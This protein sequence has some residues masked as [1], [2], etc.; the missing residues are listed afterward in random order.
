MTRIHTNAK[1]TDFT[2]GL[3]TM[4]REDADFWAWRAK[5]SKPEPAAKPGILQRIFGKVM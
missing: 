2:R 3:H 5:R 1:P 4:S